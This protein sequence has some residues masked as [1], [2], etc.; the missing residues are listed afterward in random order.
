MN[1]RTVTYSCNPGFPMTLGRIAAGKAI[2]DVKRVLPEADDVVL[3]LTS[4][5][6]MGEQLGGRPELARCATGPGG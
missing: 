5:P 6:P 4:R 1:I 3:G 2:R